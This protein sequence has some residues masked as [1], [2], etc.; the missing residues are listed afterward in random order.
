MKA[1]TILL[2]LTALPA[3]ANAESYLCVEGQVTGFNFNTKGNNW[4]KSGFHADHKYFV[5]PNSDTSLK[6]KWI[7]TQSGATVPYASSQDDFASTGALKLDGMGGQ[8]LMNKKSLRFVRTYILGY[9]TDA[10]PGEEAGSFVEGK[11][12]PVI[13]IGSC[14]VLEP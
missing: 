12:T 10:I 4:E 14:A 2:L 8:F 3:L 11:N 7:V 13:T 5:K 9:W 6:A 1:Y